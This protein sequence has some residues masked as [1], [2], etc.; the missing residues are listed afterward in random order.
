MNRLDSLLKQSKENDQYFFAVLS[1]KL[2]QRHNLID[3]LD[4]KQWVSTLRE[5]TKSLKSSVRPP[6]TFAS[7]DQD[8]FYILIE[9]IPDGDIPTVITRIT[10]STG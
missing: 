1:F 4:S 5:I 6:D 8:N 2:D 9:N 7:F 3:S 10:P